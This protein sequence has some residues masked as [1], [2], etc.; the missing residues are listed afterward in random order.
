MAMSLYQ[1]TSTE[2]VAEKAKFLHGSQHCKFL[3]FF[4]FDN[5]DFLSAVA[6]NVFPKMF[7]PAPVGVDGGA[8]VS[9]ILVGNKVNQQKHIF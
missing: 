7:S 8:N 4:I 6:T 9:Q 3:L 2:K 1:P 5:F